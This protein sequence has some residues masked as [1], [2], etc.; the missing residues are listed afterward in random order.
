LRVCHVRSARRAVS[1]SVDAK[2]DRAR[3][4]LQIINQQI[5]TFVRAAK[6]TFVLKTNPQMDEAW[7]VWLP[8]ASPY[9]PIQVSVEI[10]EFL[11]NLRSSLA[12]WSAH[13]FERRTRHPHAVVATS[14]FAPTATR[15]TETPRNS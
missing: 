2:L 11:Y 5:E 12:I 7:I 6:H 15:S 10:G 9:P 1:R 13:S 3:E 14:P 4:H 8:D